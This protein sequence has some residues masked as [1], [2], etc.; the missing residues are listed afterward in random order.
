MNISKFYLTCCSR[1]CISFLLVKILHLFREDSL[2]VGVH[3]LH[4]GGHGLHHHYHRAGQVEIVLIFCKVCEIS[5]LI[6]REYA[7]S[8]RKKQEL[9]AQIQAQLRLAD[10]MQKLE[11]HAGNLYWGRSG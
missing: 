1:H 11:D 9:R 10:T 6:R 8:W 4:P 5:Q 3:H 2:H 7:E